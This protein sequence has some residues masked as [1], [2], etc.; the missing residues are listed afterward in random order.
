LN[1]LSVHTA[2]PSGN[3]EVTSIGDGPSPSYGAVDGSFLEILV[4]QTPPPPTDQAIAYQSQVALTVASQFC[5][6]LGDSAGCL[7]LL[8]SVNAGTL[9]RVPFP[10][11]LYY[12]SSEINIPADTTFDC[13]NCTLYLIPNPYHGWYDYMGCMIGSNSTVRN[14]TLTSPG[15][16]SFG[17]CIGSGISNVEFSHIHFDNVLGTAINFGS[18]VSNVYIHDSSFQQVGYGVLMDAPFITNVTVQR[19]FFHNNSADAVAVNSPVMTNQPLAWWTVD[20][21]TTYVQVLDNV[22]LNIRNDADL[23]IGFCVSSA[24][25]HH[26][27]IANNHMSGCSWQGIH[28]E[29]CTSYVTIVNNTIDNVYGNI[30]VGWAQSLDGIWMGNTNAVSIVNNTFSRITSACVSIVAV[31]RLCFVN[32]NNPE[33]VFD[34]IFV[35]WFYQLSHDINITDNTFV[36]WG[37]DH[38]A[39]SMA[40]QIGTYPGQ[41]DAITYVTNNT[42]LTTD[43]STMIFCDCVNGVNG[44][45]VFINDPQIIA[46]GNWCSAYLFSEAAC[47]VP[48]THCPTPSPAESST[49]M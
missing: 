49:G 35:P 12:I 33:F 45:N 7:N 9:I 32:Q 4:W 17:F 10:N 22:M 14:L 47:D 43:I 30:A 8:L 3:T 27:L 19:C 36:S 15:F 42:Y 48:V 16:D 25:G 11:V 40:L 26:L 20:Y 18:N 1:A 31:N 13:N 29:D 37:L 6:G 44:T 28:L 2:L 24:G 41:E 38:G 5:I 34:G 21:V 23:S 39:H 46:T